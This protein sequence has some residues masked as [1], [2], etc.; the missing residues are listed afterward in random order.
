VSQ[1]GKIGYFKITAESAVAAGVR[2][3]EAVTAAG[4]EQY[5]SRL[6]SELGAIKNVL[7]AKD[8][9]KGVADLQ[10]DNKRLQKE[11]EHLLQAQANSL[12]EGL[13]SQFETLASGIRYIGTVLPLSDANAVKTLAYELEREIGN[14]V[15]AFGTVNAD[16][17]LLTVRI[18]DQLAKD[19][20]LNAGAIVRELASKFLKGGGGGQPGFATAGGSDTSQL[21]EAVE[22][23]RGYL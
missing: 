12:R 18:S 19:K 20:G 13:R 1:T 22:A 17:P 2:R 21:K 14:C 3:I 9:V 10:E 4:A 6:E 7:K 16:K 15:I 5:V 23:V 11:I 8:L